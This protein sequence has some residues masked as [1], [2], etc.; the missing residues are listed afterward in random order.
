MSRLATDLLAGVGGLVLITFAVI[1]ALLVFRHRPAGPPRPRQRI[2]RVFGR[3]IGG[4]QASV[5]RELRRAGRASGTRGA[6]RGRRY[7]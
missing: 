3:S 1:T 7:R 5:G 4:W 2:T 6:R